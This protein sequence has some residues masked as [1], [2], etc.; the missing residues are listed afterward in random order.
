MSTE[1]DTSLQ[2]DNTP[3]EREKAPYERL[4]AAYEAVSPNLRPLAVDAFSKF[5]RIHPDTFRKKRNGDAIVTEQEIEWM[6]AWRP[7]ATPELA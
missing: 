1:Q 4:K 6:L 5:H 3:I 7:T 2:T